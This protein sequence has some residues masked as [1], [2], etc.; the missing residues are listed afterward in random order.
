MHRIFSGGAF[1]F[2]GLIIVL[3]AAFSWFFDVIN[4][5]TFEGD[6][7]LAVRVGLKNGFLL[8]VVS[9]IMLFFGFF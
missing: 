3:L 6:H 4:E 5:A 2:I 1:F 8:F 7:T 9:E